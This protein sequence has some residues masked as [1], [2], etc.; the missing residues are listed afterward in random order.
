MATHSVACSSLH[1]VSTGTASPSFKA[2]CKSVYKMKWKVYRGQKPYTEDD[3]LF[4]VARPRGQR[5][6]TYNICM[7]ENE[8]ADFTLIF[9]H[10]RYLEFVIS[11]RGGTRAV[12][13]QTFHEGEPGEAMVTVSEGMDMAFVTSVFFMAFSH[14]LRKRLESRRRHH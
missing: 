4:T 1:A 11:H 2:D 8:D 5:R 6:G 3:L 14:T 10:P 9:N 7:R 12:A 13:K